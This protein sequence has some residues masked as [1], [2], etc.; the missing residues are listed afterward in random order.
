M[1]GVI[2]MK[3][4][5]AYVIWTAT[6]IFIFGMGEHQSTFTPHVPFLILK[7][8]NSENRLSR[9]TLD[10]LNKL[11]L[12]ETKSIEEQAQKQTPATLR[13]IDALTKK[14]IN[15]EEVEAAL[16]QGADPN[17]PI[18]REGKVYTPLTLT[19]LANNANITLMLLNFGAHPHLIGSPF[20]GINFLWGYLLSKLNFPPLPF[21]FEGLFKAGTHDWSTL[22][23]ILT[24]LSW[25]WSRFHPIY[26][27]NVFFHRLVDCIFSGGN[28]QPQAVLDQLAT[29]YFLSRTKLITAQD[30]KNPRMTANALLAS[31]KAKETELS[32]QEKAFIRD[33]FS[34]AVLI[35]DELFEKMLTDFISQLSPDSLMTA[36]AS[37]ALSNFPKAV[38]EIN[39]KISVWKIENLLHTLICLNA[40]PIPEAR[41][42]LSKMIELHRD[43]I[44]TDETFI[45]S[46]LYNTIRQAHFD[47][48]Q[49]I[50][51]HL[52]RGDLKIPRAT[53]WESIFTVAVKLSF[54]VG[55][56]DNLAFFEHLLKTAEK[57][58]WSINFEQLIAYIN[59]LKIQN[60]HKFGTL[61]DHALKI[62]A[63]FTAKGYL[64]TLYD[65]FI[66]GYLP[67]LPKLVVQINRLAPA[68][69]LG[70]L[71]AKIAQYRQ[72]FF[73]PI[74]T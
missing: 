68:V 32:D 26:I 66:K 36:A 5:Q 12:E 73:Q 37:A 7:E 49:F 63:H 71:L 59:A 41:E 28:C 27:K 40:S 64:A 69:L 8:G 74:Q 58:K 23:Y 14:T 10:H 1:H 15:K 62:I 34:I 3:P 50:F 11:A 25:E 47:H 51:Y 55:E 48:V 42:V 57:E 38:L 35:N 45:E 39:D 53:L 61:T 6:H 67:E 13:L 70:P 9:Q 30:F 56:Q 43:L 4:L 18:H 22:M 54:M 17:T 19:L 29:I 31:F 16:L 24:L 44:A 20:E 72:R 60:E 65:T 33:I 21:V 2:F 46:A 52:I